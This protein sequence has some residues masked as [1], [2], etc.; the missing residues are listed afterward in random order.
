MNRAL[1]K[2]LGPKRDEETKHWW[3]LCIE[4]YDIYP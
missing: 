1:K 2:I 4:I 3:K